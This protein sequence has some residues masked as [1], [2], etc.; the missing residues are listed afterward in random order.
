MPFD[1]GEI[2][3]FF[4]N[5]KI[6]LEKLEKTIKNAFFNFSFLVFV[7]LFIVDSNF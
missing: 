1:E 3:D 5:K 7:V 4:R 6:T 2:S